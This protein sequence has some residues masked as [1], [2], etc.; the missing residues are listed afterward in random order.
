MLS[1]ERPI[2]KGKLQVR[3]KIYANTQHQVYTFMNI[4]W[5][6]ETNPYKMQKEKSK[7]IIYQAPFQHY[8]TIRIV[9]EPYLNFGFNV[10]SPFL[11]N[12]YSAMFLSTENLLIK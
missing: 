7:H 8:L 5:K 11:S 4:K 6:K 9:K 1:K 10:V 12:S 2:T 3:G